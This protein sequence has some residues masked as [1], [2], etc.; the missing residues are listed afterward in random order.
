MG[1]FAYI[2]VCER[3]LASD[4]QDLA[5]QFVRLEF[6]KPSRVLACTFARSSLFGRIGERQYDDPHLLVL[7][8]TVRH[9]GSKQ[10][11]VGDD[12]VLTM[13]GRICM[14]NVDGLCELI[15]EEA[16]SSRIVR[17]HYSDIGGYAPRLRYRF[18]GFLGSV[19][20]T[21]GVCLQQQLPVEHFDGSQ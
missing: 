9:R 1:I 7:R 15:I 8:Y 16:N 3:L 5:N 10:V 4:I 20:A 13:Q 12:G 17:A 6:S 18:R 2:L 11:T 21:C 14:P 19:L